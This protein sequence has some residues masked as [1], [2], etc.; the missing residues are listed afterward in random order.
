[1]IR[2]IS[3][4]TKS[5]L[6][7]RS[8][9]SSFS[10]NLKGKKVVV[11]GA[12][13]EIGRNICWALVDQ[14]AEVLAV[15]LKEDSLSSLVSVSQGSGITTLKCDISDN[16]DMKR[17]EAKA[18]GATHAV[19]AAAIAPISPLLDL[20][21]EDFERVSSVNF[22]GS[23]F[24]LKAVATVISETK[25]PEGEDKCI[26]AISS[27]A[28]Q[29]ALRN[30]FSY[31]ASKGALDSMV[32]VMAMELGPLG[33][34]T[35]AVNPTVVETPLG[36][37]IWYG[38]VEENMVDRIPMG[39]LCEVMDVVWP[40]LFLLSDKTAMINGVTLPIDGGFWAAPWGGNVK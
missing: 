6:S 28:S 40:V 18:K 33:I 10:L 29:R 11:S 7:T 25:V 5:R 1:M 37:S 15:D 38:E 24:F 32:Q 17:L 36:R 26:V 14:G 16:E 27:Q 21:M 39:R 19:H 34:R 31:N 4:I 23:A 22:K 3:A 35:N 9:S 8:L 20:N 2:R 13:G 30:H 12:G